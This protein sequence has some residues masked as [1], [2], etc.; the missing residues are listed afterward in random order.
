M[1]P[2]VDEVVVQVLVEL[3]QPTHAYL[4]GLPLHV[5]V[6]VMFD[7]TEGVKL[8]APTMHDM[9]DPADDGAQKAVGT[10]L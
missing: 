6:N 8:V 9:S 10:T 3:V 7:P 4:L 5:A 2:T 1:P